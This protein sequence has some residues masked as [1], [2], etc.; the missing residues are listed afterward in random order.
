MF[1]H[2]VDITACFLTPNTSQPCE[3]DAV[4]LQLNFLIQFLFWPLFSRA[5]HA[6]TMF[7]LQAQESFLNAPTRRP[8]EVPQGR[9]TARSLPYI[10]LGT[11][12]DVGIVHIID[13]LNW[14]APKQ[15]HEYSRSRLA[16]YSGPFPPNS[17][18]S[19]HS[20]KFAVRLL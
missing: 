3:F 17:M 20:L 6:H 9:I 18:Y 1:F 14:H 5:T 11:S 8:L 2:D 12:T 15:L 7:N 16:V 19:Q 10:L 13:N 4:L